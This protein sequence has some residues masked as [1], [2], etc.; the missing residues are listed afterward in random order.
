[1]IESIDEIYETLLAISKSYK[2][3]ELKILE[4][5]KSLIKG[6]LYIFEDI[7]IQ[8][9]VNVRKPKKSFALVLNDKRIFGKDY[10]F[11]QWHLHPFENPEF[12]DESEK[13]REFVTIKEFVED[14]LF[15]IYEKLK[16]T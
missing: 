4:K 7:Y 10:I 11:G 14:A 16:I 9:Y 13:G 5:T 8:I 15:I 12:H 2:I 3:D 1:M 6:K